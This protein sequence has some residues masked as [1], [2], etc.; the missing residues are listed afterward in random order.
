ML[1]FL[2]SDTFLAIMLGL[3]VVIGA[4]YV[5]LVLRPKGNGRASK[6]KN[7]M[8]TRNPGSVQD[9]L[10]FQDIQ[11]GLV[12]LPGRR[13]RMILEVM[14][15]V[16]FPLR[17]SEEQDMVESSF[18]ALLSTLASMKSSV[19][20]Y[21]QARTLDLLPQITA[22][23]EVER[24]LPEA[25]AEYARA[26]KA[27]LTQWM[28]YAPYVTKRYLV[29]PL[30]AS[31]DLGHDQV[32]REL[33]R[34]KETVERQISRHLTCRELTTE[35]IVEML[36]NLYNKSKATSQRSK[37]A[38]TEGFFDLHPKG[39]RLSEVTGAATPKDVA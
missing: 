37:D 23:D 30:D 17:S 20:M 27:Y 25:V 36:Y 3:A 24:E 7:H 8:P 14:G 16:N 38:L 18:S 35:E 12:V 6:S 1:D 21:V 2:A 32:R 29:L 28:H 26:H 15:T 19:Q 10:G 13:Y 22:I 39:V 31:P 4:G 5:L 34:R 11:D 9:L 33:W